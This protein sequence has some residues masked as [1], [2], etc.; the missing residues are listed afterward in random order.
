MSHRTWKQAKR[1]RRRRYNAA[2]RARED[3]VWEAWLRR[4]E[5]PMAE[6][7][8]PMSEAFYGE[9]FVWPIYKKDP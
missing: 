4:I 3:R 9:P 5:G 7:L 6:H 1:R 8:K 2:I